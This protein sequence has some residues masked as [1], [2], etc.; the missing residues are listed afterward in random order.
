M[1][2]FIKMPIILPAPFSIWSYPV[3]KCLDRW[4]PTLMVSHHSMALKSCHLL[5]F[6]RHLERQGGSNLE[7]ILAADRVM[8]IEFIVSSLLLATQLNFN[9]WAL[10]Y[11]DG[12]RPLVWDTTCPDTFSQDENQNFLSILHF[13]SATFVIEDSSKLKMELNCR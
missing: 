6:Y 13:I 11:K 12:G 8:P 10:L 3:K 9:R 4:Y 5:L 2:T 1:P 7:G